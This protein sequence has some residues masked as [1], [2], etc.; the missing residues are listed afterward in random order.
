MTKPRTGLTIS[1]EAKVAGAEILRRTH[2]ASL[3]N[4]VEWLL[5]REAESM[6]INVERLMRDKRK[7]I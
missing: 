2:R 4:L 1:Q 5:L 7:E 6:Q 3:T